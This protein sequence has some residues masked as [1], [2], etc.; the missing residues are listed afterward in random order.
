LDRIKD[1]HVIRLL[2]QISE[3][4]KVNISNSFL[5]PVLL[6]IQ[7]D[8][9][10]WDLIEVL[11]EKMDLYRY[12]G[13]HLDELYRQIA[14]CARFIEVARNK[15]TIKT[16]LSLLPVGHDKTLRDMAVSNFSSNLRV[17]SDLLNELYVS[18]VEMDKKDCGTTKEPVYTQIPEL[19]NIG[20][21]L[22]GN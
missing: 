18:L 17:F 3:H 9:N 16:K 14:A 6:Q 5:R 7:I 1:P 22:V 12:Q 19:Y 10:T 8:K 13:F 21:L 11:T 20:R 2:E 15:S 4:Y